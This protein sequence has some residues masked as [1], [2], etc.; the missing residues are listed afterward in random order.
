[1]LPSLATETVIRLRGT[2]SDNGYGDQ[3]ID[4]TTPAQLPISGC[5]VQPVAGTE[6]LLDRDAVVSRWTLYAPLGADILP[7]DR[8][9]HNGAD[10]DV[11]GSVQDWPDAFGLGHT[12]ALLRRTSG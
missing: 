10:Y 11:D 3:F 9:R 8:I 6:Y 12:T 4:W 2:S 1:M 7:S 5:S